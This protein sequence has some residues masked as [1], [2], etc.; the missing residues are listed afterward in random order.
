LCPAA[1]SECWQVRLPDEQIAGAFTGVTAVEVANSEEEALAIAVILRA[2]VEQPGKTA[3]LVTPDRALARRV[4]AALARWD[5]AVDDSGGDRLGELPAGVLARLAAEATIGGLPPPSLLALLKHPLTRFGGRSGEGAAL[6]VMERAILRGPRPRPGSAGLRQALT[7][8]RGT[9]ASLH[10]RDPRKHLSG[11]QLDLA[12]ALIERLAVALAPLENLGSEP[13]SFA[14]LA[15]RHRAVVAALTREGKESVAF[16]PDEGAALALA[17]DEIAA[18]GG[19]FMVV[20][21]EYPE[22]FAAVIGD[23]VVRRPS[24]P[25]VRV[26]IFGLLEARLQSADL[27]VLGG[28]VEGTWPPD[29]QNDAWLSRPMRQELGLDLPERRIGLTAHDFAQVLG[30]HE[31]VLTRAAKVA[32]APTLWSRFAQRLAAVAGAAT[33]NEALARGAHYLTLARELDRPA[34]VVPIA[35]P[36]PCPPLAARPKRLSVTEIEDWLRDPYTIYARHVLRLRPLDPIDTPPGAADRGSAIHG[37]IGDFT[38][39]W[40][41]RIPP[42]PIGE[43]TRLGREHFA[44]LEDFPEARA[45]WW[46]RF[47]RICR[48]F[49]GWEAER[50]S[51]LDTIHAEVAGEI[52]IPVA[53]ETFVLRG[54]ADRI[55]RRAGGGYVILDY[56]TGQPPSEKQVRC[57]FA[58][59]LPLEAAI[60]RYGAFAGVPAG[61]SVEQ[62]IYVR[63]RGGEPAAEAKPIEFKEGS[64]DS[65][66]DK[67][68]RR[69]TA[70]VTRFNDPTQPYRSLLHPMWI[71]KTRYGDYDHLARVK[72]WS[73]TA[74]LNDMDP[75]P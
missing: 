74:G 51:A 40:S 64:P 39:L 36:V 54:R 13:R 44:P 7:T 26:R 71:W 69:L 8:L 68:L 53:G 45:F 67:A 37:A 47:L 6:D 11:R 52:K 75:L 41:G 50:R 49:A 58:P 10:D 17:F 21:A 24:A 18:S 12:S 70:I 60:L 1:A 25:G 73:L 56:K 3:A 28:L 66:A 27:M 23:R 4:I 57:G 65:Q 43:L 33:W 9:Q 72:E 14:D 31:V 30:A 2:A 55:E 19:S 22:L 20:P 59:Q 63:L 61:G 32:G 35:V 48:W 62:L 42:D 34:K 16:A 29:A 15:S 5:V 38:K 46:P